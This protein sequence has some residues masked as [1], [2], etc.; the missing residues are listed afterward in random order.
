[1]RLEAVNELADKR[2]ASLGGECQCLLENVGRVAFHR[3]ILAVESALLSE[4]LTPRG[5]PRQKAMVV[6]QLE[7]PEPN[8]HLGARRGRDS[9]A[10]KGSHSA[11]ASCRCLSP[12][13]RAAFCAARL[14]SLVT[15]GSGA[16]A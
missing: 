13:I 1:M 12:S 6:A 16:G 4:L 14:P 7:V 15:A 9:I 11:P 10:G 3:L 8:K 5:G 2:C